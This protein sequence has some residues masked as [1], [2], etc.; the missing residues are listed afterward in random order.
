MKRRQPTYRNHGR[1]FTLIETALATIIVGVGVLSMVSAQAAFHKQNNWST[2]ASTATRLGNEIREM[3]LNLP[4]LDPVTGAIVWGAEA[5]ETSVADFDD[6]DDFDGTGSGLVFSAALGN[7]PLN[8]QREI[9]PNMAGWEQVVTVKNVDPFDIT[10]VEADGS[11]TMIMVEVIVTYQGPNDSD[12]QEMTR[13][14]WI[15]PN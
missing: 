5:N 8:A 6:L 11:T 2:H 9:I 12:P 1:G 13:V 4:R 10:S 3:T 15:S 14:T 7:G